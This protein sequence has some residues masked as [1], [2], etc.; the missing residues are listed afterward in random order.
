MRLGALAGA[1]DDLVKRSRLAVGSNL[2][3]GRT[4][5]H[6]HESS[7]GDLEDVEDGSNFEFSS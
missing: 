5:P 2:A 7:D 4:S 1:G 6:H 3:F